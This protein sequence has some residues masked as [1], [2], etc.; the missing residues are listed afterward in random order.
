MEKNLA[1]SNIVL[2]GM[3]AVGKSTIGVILAKIIGYQFV[4]T[5]LLIQADQGKRLSE[6]IAE[7]GIDGFLEVENRV[8]ASVDAKRSVIATGGSAVY[9]EE[10]MAH[11]KRIGIVVYLKADFETLSKRLRNIKQRGVTLREGQTLKDLYDERTALY[12]K[13]A[14]LVVEE[15]GEIEDTVTAVI[16]AMA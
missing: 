11:L 15:D 2:I 1:K 5:D 8:N 10:A 14:D 9:G 16:K 12:E 7:R 3:P 4:D 13:Y 6:I